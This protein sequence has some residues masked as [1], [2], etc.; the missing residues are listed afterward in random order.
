MTI[1]H[2]VI[3]AVE[4]DEHYLTQGADGTAHL[5]YYRADKALSYVWSGDTA[6]VLVSRGG[7]AEPVIEGIRLTEPLAGVDSL[8]PLTF[9]RVV[10]RFRSLCDHHADHFQEG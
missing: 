6:T 8:G 9:R 5:T 10:E 2:F 7:Y 1:D 4:I 3:P